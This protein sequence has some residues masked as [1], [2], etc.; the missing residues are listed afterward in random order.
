[1]LLHASLIPPTCK[2]I[3]DHKEHIE[4]FQNVNYENAHMQECCSKN[5]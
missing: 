5:M 1:M 4:L 2:I 3:E